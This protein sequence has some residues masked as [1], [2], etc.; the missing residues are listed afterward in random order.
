MKI[1]DKVRFS[2]KVFKAPYT[3]WYNSY[4]G[5]EFSVVGFHHGNTHVE[6]KCTTGKI[7]VLGYVHPD[8][9]VILK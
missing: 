8:E 5:H 4:K 3:P 9:L 2:E 7:K 6:V 1:G